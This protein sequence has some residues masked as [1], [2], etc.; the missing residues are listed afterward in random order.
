MLPQ[1][2]NFCPHTNVEFFGDQTQRRIELR[3][4]TT[5]AYVT[6]SSVQD[7]LATGA[8]FV[9]ATG[10]GYVHHRGQALFCGGLQ[11]RHGIIPVC[12]K[13]IRNYC[14]NHTLCKQLI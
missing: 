14:R 2:T 9:P 11:M 1:Q 3:A 12:R 10:D 5:V 4:S 8:E 7:Q 6:P 13:V